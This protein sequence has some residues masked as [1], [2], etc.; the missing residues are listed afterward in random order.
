M[1]IC[2]YGLVV[3]AYLGEGANKRKGAYSRKYNI[4]LY[5]ENRL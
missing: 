4:N 5:S 3:G 1:L 2:Y